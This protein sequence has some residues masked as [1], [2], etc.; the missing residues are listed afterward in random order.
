M[1]RRSLLLLVV[2]A[3]LR[4]VPLLMGRWRTVT[5]TQGGIGALYEF[6]SGG[7]ATYSSAA[8]VEM[9]YRLDQ[10]QLTLGGQS[11][12]IGFHPDGGLQLNYGK[13]QIEDFTRQGKGADATN[14]ILGEWKGSRMM[15]NRR[16][17]V[18]LQFHGGGRALVIYLKA[19]GCRYQ[20]GPPSSDAWIMT[21]V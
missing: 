5:T 15:E 19:E 3:L 1:H 2:P 18:T 10:N 9:D 17:P 4:G 13:N 14:P 20:S 7:K 21:P 8:I 12:G 11:V 16:L 6:D